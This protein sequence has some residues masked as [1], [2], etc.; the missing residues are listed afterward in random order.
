MKGE[1][2]EAFKSKEFDAAITK[3][4]EAMDLAE[5]NKDESEQ[6]T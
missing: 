4:K 5:Y 1:A 3:Y 6:M 2:N